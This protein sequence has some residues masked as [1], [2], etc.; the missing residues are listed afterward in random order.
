MRLTES[1]WSQKRQKK[2]V[3]QKTFAIFY[4]TKEKNNFA[5]QRAIWNFLMIVNLENSFL[6]DILPSKA[7]AS[8]ASSQ[9]EQ[10]SSPKAKKVLFIS[11]LHSFRLRFPIYGPLAGLN[12][13]KNGAAYTAVEWMA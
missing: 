7:W 10:P 5:K 3:K 6:L 9:R 8:P 11:F 1:E 13:R 4:G 2:R 12:F